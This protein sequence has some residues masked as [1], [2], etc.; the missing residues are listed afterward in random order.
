M[1]RERI[2]L[3][4]VWRA[5]PDISEEGERR[6]WHL[7]G[8]D[9]RLW[10]EV[11]VPCTFDSVAPGLESYEGPVLFRRMVAIPSSWADRHVFV[12]FEG[13]N[14]HA[15][16]WLNGEEVGRSEDGFLRFD[17]PVDGI[18]R[19]G[20]EN[21][22]VVRADTVRRRGEV[23]G[24][25]RG[26][27][28]FGGILRE[29]ELWAAGKVRITAIATVAEPAAE[30]GRLAV[31]LAI[32]N[33]SDDAVS[34]CPCVRVCGADGG[35]VAEET[36]A[37]V[38]L[39]PGTK[40][41]MEPV[42]K[43]EGV[44]P[45]S[46]DRPLLYSAEVSL[47]SGDDLLDR[48]DLKVGFRHVG[49]GPEGVRLNGEPIFLTGFNRHEDSPRTGPCPDLE[50]VRNDL[51]RMKDAGCNFVRLCHYP[52]H[53][54]ELDLCDELGLLVMAEIPLYWWNGADEGE[55]HCRAKLAA[56]GRQ[57]RSMIA[58]DRNHASV[59]FWSVSNETREEK[60]EV[61]EGNAAL[62]RLARAL[63]PSRLAVHV[64]DRWVNG[65]SFEEDDVLC[66]NSYPTWHNWGA[67]KGGTP[68]EM[69]EATA[70]WVRELAA[71]HERHPG[72]PIIVTEFGHPSLE[73]VFDTLMGE[74]T[75]SEAI[76][77]QVKAFTAPY[78]CGATI[79]CWADHPWPE[80]PFIRYLTVSPFGLVTRSRKAL[81]A[82]ATVRRLFRERQGMPAESPR[83]RGQDAGG[84]HVT[85][86]RPNLHDIPVFECPEGFAI[87]PMRPDEGPVWADI[88]RDAEPFFGIADEL[89]LREF[90]S[91]LPAVPRRCFFV[92][93]DKG[94][95]VATAS[96]WYSRQF[97][98]GDWGRIHWVA[99]RRAYRRLGLARAAV[100]Y[101][102]RKL[103]EWHDRAYLD[104][105]TARLGAIRL[106]LDCG[107]V[108]DLER[109][110]AAEAWRQVR[111]GLSHPA[112]DALEL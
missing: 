13:V 71:L 35:A 22:L 70:F 83:A 37:A 104:T 19:P 97:R 8:C 48:Q 67:E 100:S 79:W 30:G 5:Q 90:G 106:Y 60:P 74:D 111:Q 88:H 55:E 17:V 78:V 77:A 89:F 58:R 103:A 9:I 24:M 54:R 41:E 1:E 109:D 102:L 46:P 94:A 99:T 66:V 65:G 43:C 4:G 40:V 47:L 73:D 34:V 68:P 63:D 44:D 80:E 7:P 62:M 3:C 39:P 52:H 23:P 10:R 57:L 87:R 95:A 16:V 69:A 36:G 59:I 56:A 49:V 50:T 25:E 29:V 82:L 108:P 64:S 21:C 42:L 93:D 75:Q 84:S 45:W 53:P 105:A 85:M 86:L 11:E 31:R 76:E 61:A 81:R 107:F 15:R 96:A 26:W 28:P 33:H 51:R 38:A 98:G 20:E 112:L 12:R 110:G 101:A 14:Y 27:K 18:A 2:D 6:G 72:K 91:D 92:V 32:V